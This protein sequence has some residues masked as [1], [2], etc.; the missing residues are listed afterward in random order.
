MS[1]V[2]KYKDHREL[3]EAMVDLAREELEHFGQVCRLLFDRG[4]SIANDE[5]DDYVNELLAQTRATN[6]N[7]RLLD[8]LIV[9]GIVEARSCERFGILS[10]EHPEPFMR[11]FYGRLGRA[12]ARHQVFFVHLA[13]RYFP[14]TLVEK[15]L[16]ELLDFEDELVARLPLR[17][18]V[19]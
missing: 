17:A 5:R 13:E 12:E 7:R 6:E 1:L 2:A 3:V 18:G 11:E 19:H 8:R 9:S 14:K 4:L 15:R 10:R 16:N